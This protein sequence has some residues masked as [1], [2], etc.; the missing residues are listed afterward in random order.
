MIAYLGAPLWYITLSPA[1]N[2][3]PICL[4]FADNKEKMSVKLLQSDD[5]CCHLIANNP[6]ASA[7]FFILWLRCSSNMSLE[8]APTIE[9]CMERHLV[10]M[11]L[12][13][14]RAI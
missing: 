5:K 12:L 2:K 13:S 8:W 9:D 6:V 3:H 4:Y 11:A 10:I 7:L 14:S 1:D